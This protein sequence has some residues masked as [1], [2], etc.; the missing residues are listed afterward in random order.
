M[1]SFKPA[2]FSILLVATTDNTQDLLLDYLRGF[3]YRVLLCTDGEDALLV[4]A[5]ARPDIILLDVILPGINGF[6]TCRRLKADSAT[7]NIPVIFITSQTNTVDKVRGFMLGAV[8]YIARPIQSEEVLARLKTH[9]L[10]QNLQN[11]LEAHNQ[12]LSQEIIE[13]G[14]LIAELDAFAHTVAHDLKNPLGVTIS[15]AQF[16]RKFH[17]RMTIEE[18]E[19]N[20]EMIIK[21]GHKMNNIIYELMLLSSVR[22]EEVEPTPLDMAEIVSEAVGRLSFLISEYEARVI[23]PD[24]ASWPQVLGYAPW[25]EEVWINYLSNAIKYGG[26]SPLVEMGATVQPNRQVKFWV[27]DS[28]AGILPEAQPKLFIP[29]IRLNQVRA[30][31]HGLGLSIVQRIM[32]KLGG[33]VGV[34]SA[35]GAGSTFSFYLPL[36]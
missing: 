2:E 18:F 24:E 26:E 4:A 1:T 29:F 17:H 9:L 8:D 33:Q 34:E 35:V 7:Q 36:A 16:L 11:D 30:E 12:Q 31:G 6:E 27:R 10:L 13:R 15:Q 19:E 5:H 3:G 21:N 25:I 23:I 14:K 28:G 20:L 22:I 32:N